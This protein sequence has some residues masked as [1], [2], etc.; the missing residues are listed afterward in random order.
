[1]SE[2]PS[3]WI[4]AP[5]KECANINMGQSPEGKYVGENKHGLPFY[6][7]KAE[8]G[9]TYP[10]PRKYC[11]QPTKIAQQNDIL[12]SI[13]APVGPT[14]LCPEESCI[15]RGLASIRAHES[16]HQ[17]YLLRYFKHIEPWLSQQGTGSTFKAISGGF[18]SDVEVVIA[19]LNEQIRIADKLDSVLVKVDAAQARLEKIPVLLKRFRQSVLAAATS[20]ELTDGANWKSTTIDSLCESSFYGPR[21]SKT[22]YTI[23]GIPT[24][25]TTDMTDDGKIVISD[26]TPR[27]SVPDE[28]IEQFKVRKGDLLITRTG[29]IGVMAVFDDDYLAL[30]SAYLIR[31]RFN[32]TVEV[33]FLYYFLTSPRGQELMG[34]GVTTVAQPNINAKTIRAIAIDLPSIEEQKEI[35]RRV[36][37]LFTLADTVEKQY[38]ETKKR[39]DRLTQSLLAKAFRG[40][41]VP[42]DP[43][44]EPAAELLK[45]I[46]AE[47]NAQPPVKNKRAKSA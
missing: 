5:L 4:T 12:L 3:T 26:S 41:L 23:D 27:I 14:N 8:F 6:Q 9:K 13:R 19:P 29:S 33:K 2:L 11:I 35:V 44:D 31:F 34:L 25:R 40:E 10:T 39:T 45:R 43:S 36:E 47:R 18:L 22:D 32:H 28:K 7:G 1:M 42:Q 16:L 17:Q 46:Q 30:P 20:G 24:I 15:G 38:L 37:S 21:F